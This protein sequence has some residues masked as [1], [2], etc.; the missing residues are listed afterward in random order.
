MRWYVRGGLFEREHCL[1]PLCPALWDVP[2]RRCSRV[3]SCELWDEELLLEERERQREQEQ[4][5]QERIGLAY[6][7]PLRLGG[8]RL[9]IDPPPPP[10]RP[11]VHD[12]NPHYH[13]H[14]DDSPDLSWMND[15]GEL[16]FSSTVLC[17]F[18]NEFSQMSSLRATGSPST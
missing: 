18:L 11:A 17:T 1:I 10:Y 13:D 12:Y 2:N 5:R 8:A 6:L 4:E 14:Y 16:M 9:V 7:G 3:P 15:S